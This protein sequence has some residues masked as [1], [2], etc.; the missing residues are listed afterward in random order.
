I[1][2][3]S[4]RRPLR[5][6]DLL[7]RN[8]FVG[9]NTQEMGDA[10]EAC[11]F[12]IVGSNDVPRSILSIRDIEHL[13]ASMRVVVPTFAGGQVRWAELPL[14]QR[15]LDPR[16]EPPLLFLIAYFQ[17]EFDQPDPSFHEVL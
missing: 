2:V 13:I 7:P 5:Q 8:L 4:L 11:S 1:V 16:L 6:F 15:I 14:A 17:P 10:I 3:R 9:N 12:L